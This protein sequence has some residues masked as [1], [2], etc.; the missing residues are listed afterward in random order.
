MVVVSSLIK[1][2]YVSDANANYCEGH[3]YGRT[4]YTLVLLTTATPGC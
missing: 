2:V 4:L 1:H 3:S